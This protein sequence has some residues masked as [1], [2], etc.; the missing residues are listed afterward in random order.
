MLSRFHGSDG[1]SDGRSTFSAAAFICGEAADSG[2]DI[3]AGCTAWRLALLLIETDRV[4]GE[5]VPL[6]FVVG[7][8]VPL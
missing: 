7:Q 8:G 1:T 4:Y 3:R 2:V 5:D 6:L